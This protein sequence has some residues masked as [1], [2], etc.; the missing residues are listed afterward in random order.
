MVV[1]AFEFFDVGFGLLAV[2]RVFQFRMF[3]CCA[4]NSGFWFGLGVVVLWFWVLFGWVVY[5]CSCRFCVLRR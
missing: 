1:L 4:L 2:F 3:V 5:G